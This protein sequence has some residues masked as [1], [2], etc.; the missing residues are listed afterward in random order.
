ML[1][2]FRQC[3]RCPGR[4]QCAVARGRC[5]CAGGWRRDLMSARLLSAPFEKKHVL[6]GSQ[7]T[8]RACAC[9]LRIRWKQQA[10]ARR[11]RMFQAWKMT[12]P[13]CLLVVTACGEVASDVDEP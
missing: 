3:W 9:V 12:L 11:T 7:L 13:A 6:A 1:A 10:T 2:A 4:F 8:H 5:L